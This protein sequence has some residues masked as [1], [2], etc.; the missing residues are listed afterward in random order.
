M[1]VRADANLVWRT[2]RTQRLS[3]SRSGPLCLAAAAVLALIASEA[4]ADDFRLLEIDGHR[5]KWGA[6]G[7][8]TGAEV[9]YGFAEQA[10]SF[11]DA[12]NC[13]DLAPMQ[14]LAHAWGGEPERL[15]AIAADAFAMWSVAANLRFRPAAAGE[16][17]DILIGAQAL[18]RRIA[19]AN[20]W[21][22]A[23]AAEDGVAPLER[24][25]ICFNPLFPWGAS[26][27]GATRFSIDFGTVLAHE[28][29]HAIGLDHP[30]PTGS[31]MGYQNQGD[32]D[33]L[34]PGDVEGAIT[35]YGPL[36]AK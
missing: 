13:G 1:G 18:P 8:G 29:G 23:A 11:P 25:T 12:V 7:L 33:A 32:I 17:P 9:T 31:L 30:G 10:Q 22:D 34:M 4:R 26:G 3:H 14:Q 28:I 19:F 36:P 35:L 15:E 16:A 5:M 21:F 20:V 24:A 6:A 27:S 2:V